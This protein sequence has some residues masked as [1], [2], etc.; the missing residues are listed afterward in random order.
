MLPD[1][2]YERVHPKDGEPTVD[3][4]MWLIENRGVWHSEE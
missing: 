1:G 3:S 2:S 4:Q